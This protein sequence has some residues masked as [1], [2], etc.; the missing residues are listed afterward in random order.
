MVLLFLPSATIA[1]EEIAF[2]KSQ[3][4]IEQSLRFSD[5]KSVLDGEGYEVKNGKVYRVINNRRFRLRG[6]HVV[7]A[8]DI[9]PRVGALIHFD[10][11]SAEIR[12]DSYPLLNEFGKALKGGL[13]DAT[14]I[15]AGHTD[16]IGSR[17]YNQKLSEERAISVKNY[18]LTHHGIESKRLV[19]NGLGETK[20]IASNDTDD[21][22]LKNRRVEFIRIQ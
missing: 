10:F 20:P 15:I 13:T 19:I 7:S 9:I 8:L 6:M 21:G 16:N 1:A 5:K 17:E 4:E 14:I 3:D 11:D 18:L 22:R 12:T 2:P